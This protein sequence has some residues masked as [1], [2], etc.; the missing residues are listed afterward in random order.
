MAEAKTKPTDVS[1]TDYLNSIA[2][3]QRRQDCFTVLEL[4]KKIVK[5]EPKM[6][7]SSIV[8]VGSYHYKYA[9][10]HEGDSCITGFASRKDALVL[11]LMGRDEKFEAQ[12]V[13]LGKY[14]SGKGCL[15]IKKLAD[16]DLK[17]LQA[18][19]K[20]SVAYVKSQY[21]AA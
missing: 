13:K 15:Y 6:W 10:G 8:G 12:L 17:I 9:S 3:E 20:S 21:K 4:M 5:A 19:I 11:Y 18:L 7:G 16:V 14:K 2:D 1:V